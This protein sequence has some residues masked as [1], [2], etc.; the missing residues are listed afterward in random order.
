MSFVPPKRTL[1][2]KLKGL[3]ICSWKGHIEIKYRKWSFCERCGLWW[4]QDNEGSSLK[5]REGKE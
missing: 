5:K 2:E 1:I 3:L 4:P